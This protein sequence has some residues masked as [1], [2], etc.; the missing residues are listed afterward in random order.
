M[1]VDTQ[2]YIISLF[3][4]L[5]GSIIRDF[6]IPLFVWSKHLHGKSY[7]YRFWFC[8]ITQAFI[9]INLVLFL[10]ILNVLSSGTYIVLNVLLYSLIKWNYSNKMIFRNA[11]KYFGNLWESI[12]ENRL[13]DYLTSSISDRVK[14][15]KRKIL[16]W[17][18]W[19]DI[20]THWLEI[21]L[22]FIIVIYNIW[23]F[24][25]NV[26]YYHSYQFSDI[27]VHQS[28][29]YELE[30]G[31][32]YVD[33][34]YP[35]GM[36]IMI[37]FI[38]VFLNINLGE[39]MLYAGAYQSVILLI[40]I[41]FLAKEIF[42]GKYI[43]IAAIIINSLMINQGRYA[44]ALPQE[45]GMYAV[46]AIAY[47]MIRYL[48]K[49]KGKFKLKTD[50][51]IKSFFRIKT[52]INRRYIDY[53]MI[54]LMLSVSLVISYHYYT[55]IAAVI[56][57]LS[58][59]IAF[60]FRILK[61]QY[62]IPLL[63]VGIM[64]TII[65]I[66]PTGVCLVKGTPFQESIDWAL[67]VMSGEE[68]KG[69][70]T[71]YQDKL[72]EA[73]EGVSL[74]NESINDTYM[75]NEVYENEKTINYSQMSIKEIIEYYYNTILN[76]GISTMFGYEATILMFLSMAIDFI[77]SILMLLNKKTRVF[78]YTYIA[79]I[80]VM[81]IFLT[82]GASSAL[83]IPEIIAAGRAST[84]AQPFIGIIYILSVDFVFRISHVFKNLY[85]Q[86]FV[87]GLS[88]GVCVFSV[89]II[90][91][92]GWY[93]D[94][95]DIYLAY[96]NETE[97]VIRNIKQNFEKH[98]Y[99]IVSTTDEYYNVVDHGRHTQL[100]KLVNMIDKNEENFHFNTEY[101]F[102]FIEKKILQDYNYGSVMVNPYYA[103]K[104]FVYIGDSQ[105]YY[106]QRAVI[107]S[108]AYYWA[109]EFQEIYPRNF[110]IYFED[111][112]Y[113]VYML[114]QNTYYPYNLQIDFFP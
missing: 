87:N 33:G 53:D 77:S 26:M 63:F 86:R 60:L 42:V 15:I 40:G 103:R 89:L 90:V 59:G 38:R 85:Y 28:W 18:I 102:F 56:L 64:G 94:F 25:N 52:Y 39:I 45:V 74:E 79:F 27:P 95:F 24:T 9:Q 22:I 112:I 3:L 34:I 106:F 54:L 5:I 109:K 31:N 7:S 68:W 69:S 93:H 43:P 11:K 58:I 17:S 101:V 19:K 57:I 73:L 71:E 104:D 92:F 48:R 37:Y 97:Y 8:T 49:D 114:E 14:V 51:K 91:E 10:G 55:A 99:T 4:V 66:L 75:D 35:F 32:L 72:K 12:I 67:T 41:Y 21:L 20:K 84:F 76:F 70:D 44:A 107:E 80:I 108:K 105:D 110:K 113:I 13:L 98:T 50:S 30:Q 1:I 62:F 23:F 100:S 46:V 16:D 111:D 96:Y 82:L 88:L 2:A 29:I 78:G 81:Q 36:H 47:F 83:G 6:G 61:K 65:A